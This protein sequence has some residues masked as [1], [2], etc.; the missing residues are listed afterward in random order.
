VVRLWCRT[1]FGRKSIHQVASGI[2]V[3]AAQHLQNVRY[4]SNSVATANEWPAQVFL[5]C[6]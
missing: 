1:G 6:S 3:S 5:L 4:V 2:R